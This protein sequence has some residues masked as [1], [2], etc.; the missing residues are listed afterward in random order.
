MDGVATVV[1]CRSKR[2]DKTRDLHEGFRDARRIPAGDLERFLEQAD[3]LPGIR[4]VQRALR[5]RMSSALLQNRGL[6][7][8]GTLIRCRG[9]EDQQGR[10]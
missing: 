8:G 5:Q 6:R 1:G 2:C 3:R 9:H 4:A 10:M 7:R